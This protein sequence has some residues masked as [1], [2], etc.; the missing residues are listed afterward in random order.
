MTR[1][2]SDFVCRFLFDELD[3][4][5]TVVRLGGAWRSMQ[6]GR[7]YPAPVRDLLGEM[8]AVAV[9]IGGNLEQAARLTFQ[10]EGDGPVRLMVIDCTEQLRIRGL[11]KYAPGIAPAPAA[12]LLGDG[13]LALLLQGD[14]APEPYQSV[15]PLVGD[16][17]AQVFEH[18]LAQSEQQQAR[19]WLFA[20]ADYA[21]GLFLQKLPGADAKDPDGW[22]R[23]AHL[24]ATVTA[25]ELRELPPEALLPRLFPEE[26]VRVF[27][28]KPVAY[29]C[30]EDPDKVRD[31]L[32]SLGREEVEAIIETQG[33]LVVRDDICN[34]EYRFDASDLDEIFPPEAPPPRTLH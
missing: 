22:A 30:P 33:E 10:L 9:L 3:I 28:P 8:T 31:M 14:S 6:E 16:T 27:T 20:A 18:Y 34:H 7:G 32:R 29:E 2:K 23:I 24:A 19:L 5:G 11:A 13:R 4:R 25:K 17:L 21:V 1:R 15:V 26:A 12:E